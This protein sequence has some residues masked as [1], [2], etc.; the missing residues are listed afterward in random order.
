MTVMVN[1]SDYFLYANYKL[2][3]IAKNPLIISNTP[4][5]DGVCISLIPIFRTIRVKNLTST[6]LVKTSASWCPDLKERYAIS[7]WWSAW[8][9]R[10]ALFYHIATNCGQCT[11]VLLSHNKKSVPIFPTPSW[12]FWAMSVHKSQHHCSILCF[13]TGS[14]NHHLFLTET[15]DQIP[16]SYEC[17][18]TC[19]W[20]PVIEVSSPIS[21]SKALDLHMPIIWEY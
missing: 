1:D 3:F 7:L 6:P 17:A 10:H 9:S 2:L 16:S 18:I 8:Q 14:S 5:W 21:I 20:F 4:P 15:I 19:C 13:Y 11:A 12:T